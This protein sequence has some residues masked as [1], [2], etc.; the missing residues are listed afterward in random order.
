MLISFNFVGASHSKY[1]K[2]LQSF[3]ECHVMIFV[4]T[5]IILHSHDPLGSA[6]GR[7]GY[8]GQL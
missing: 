4:Y 2:V 3:Q 8:N 6:M 1:I 7:L 5:A